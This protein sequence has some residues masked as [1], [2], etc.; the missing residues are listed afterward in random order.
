MDIR[1]TNSLQEA[2]SKKHYNPCLFIKIIYVRQYGL[3][4]V[5]ANDKTVE[6]NIVK[7]RGYFLTS[8]L[9]HPLPSQKNI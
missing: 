8:S 5:A 2:Q 9:S 7:L 6:K 3:K 4:M 1:Y